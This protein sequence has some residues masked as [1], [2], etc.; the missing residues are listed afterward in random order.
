MLKLK[1]SVEEGILNL[2]TKSELLLAETDENVD[3]TVTILDFQQQETS[4]LSIE[5]ESEEN[6]EQ[7][8]QRSKNKR[9]DARKVR[10]NMKFY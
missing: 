1:K 6:F 10:K 4:G 8:F 2:L 3:T 9:F 5:E 7:Q